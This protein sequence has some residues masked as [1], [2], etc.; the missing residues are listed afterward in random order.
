M[1]NKL[2]V[3]GLA[4]G[5]CLLGVGKALQTCNMVAQDNIFG[6]TWCGPAG[7]LSPIAGVSTNAA[8]HCAGCYTMAFGALMM[9]FMTLTLV[10]KK[11]ETSL[12][13]PAMIKN[14]AR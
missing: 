2:R 4:A 1:L 14:M 8:L 7:E 3:L 13:M 11:S 12:A 5:A 9:F 10:T 6:A